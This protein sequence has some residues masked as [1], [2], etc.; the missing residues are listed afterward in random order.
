MENQYLASASLQ[1]A[2]L[3]CKS[4]EDTTLP[5]SAVEWKHERALT[6]L[7]TLLERQFYYWVITLDSGISPFI[8]S[9]IARA[10]IEKGAHVLNRPDIS[11]KTKKLVWRSHA[12]SSLQQ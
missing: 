4:R 10:K 11:K 5:F 7:L 1:N 3:D 8:I 6:A 2:K 9:T 12:F